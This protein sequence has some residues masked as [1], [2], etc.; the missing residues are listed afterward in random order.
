MKF[1]IDNNL[2]YKLVGKLDGD[3]PQSVHV[4]DALTVFA[5]DRQI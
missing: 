5:M 2:S 3:F 1:L 4:R